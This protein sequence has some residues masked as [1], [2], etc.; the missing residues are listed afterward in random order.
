[1][2]WYIVDDSYIGEPP[3]VRTMF[4]EAAPKGGI[5][6]AH[7]P[8]IRAVSCDYFVWQAGTQAPTHVMQVRV[9]SAR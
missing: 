8:Y 6:A 9:S 2:Q 5:I 1:M 7:H 3:L 4:L